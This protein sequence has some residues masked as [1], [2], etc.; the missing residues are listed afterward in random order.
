MTCAGCSVSPMRVQSF[1]LACATFA[2]QHRSWLHSSSS[3]FWT[4][5]VCVHSDVTSVEFLWRSWCSSIFSVRKPSTCGL[6][7]HGAWTCPSLAGAMISSFVKVCVVASCNDTL[8][9]TANAHK[10]ATCQLGVFHMRC[11]RMVPQRWI[12]ECGSG[13]LDCVHLL[14]PQCGCVTPSLRQPTHPHQPSVCHFA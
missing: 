5:S 12:L 9:K 1:G 3:R 11:I 8:E 13:T 6:S 2:W 7:Q 10:C 4:V 14:L